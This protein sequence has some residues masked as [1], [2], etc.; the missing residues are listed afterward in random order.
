MVMKRTL[1]TLVIAGLVVF[2]YSQK[3]T[4]LPKHL[5]DVVIEKEHTEAISDLGAFQHMVS[6]AVTGDRFE[7]EEDQIG[8]TWYDLQSNTALGNRMYL[9]ND[10]TIAAT[11]TFGLNSPNFSGRGTGY[12]YFDGAEWGPWPTVRIE[13]DRCGWPSIAAWGEDGE[14]NVAHLSGGSEVGLYFNHRDTKGTG[15]WNEFLFQGPPPDNLDLVW[16]RLV[17]TGTNH[18]VIHL[19]CTTL[20]SGNGG[21]P[22]QGMDPALLYSRSFDGGA[23][24]DP[25]NIILEGTGPD[26]YTDIGGDD[27]TFAEPRGDI[28]A[29]VHVDAWKDLFV[30]KSEDAGDT[31]EK[32]MIWE[33][34]YPFFDWNSTITTDTLWA[35]DH[36]ADCAIDENGKVHVV[37]GLTRVAHFEVGTTYQYWPYT[38][39]VAYWNEDR[40]P[41]EAPDMH[42]ALD[43]WDVLTPDYDLVGWLLGVDLMDEIMSYRELGLTTMVQITAT[44]ANQLIVAFAMTTEGYDNGTYNYKHIWV[45]GSDDNGSTWLDFYDLNTDLIHIFDECIYPVMTGNTDGAFHLLYQTDSEP[46]TALD[47]DHPYQENIMYYSRM[48]LTDIGLTWTGEEEYPAI[49]TETVSQNYPNPFSGSTYVQAE[50]MTV[51]DLS[52]EVTNLMGQKVM[53]IEK[54][55]VNPGKHIF[56]IN[57]EDL[58]PGVYFYTVRAGNNS[59]ARKMIVE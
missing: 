11:W 18:D 35:P 29:F 5:R 1:L 36:S 50:T 23:T 33:H 53:E 42:D 7:Q 24:W 38:D 31:W 13:S 41:F 39:G 44:P 48:L 9:F 8:N 3:R 4:M 6:P 46:G 15:T 54:G 2:G 52:L 20:P 51:T 37:V 25:E 19:I 28:I 10:G 32:H 47:E 26:Y 12:N 49:R 56:R 43:A 22:Y 55:E 34:P 59:V 27:Y 30:M 45:R 57:A 58:T 14:I 21:V 17:T 16:P 40:P